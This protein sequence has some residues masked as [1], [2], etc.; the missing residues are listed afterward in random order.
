M[1]KLRI[2]FLHVAPITGDVE[3]NRRLVE[4]AV[5]VAAGQGADWAVTPELCIPGY[6]FMARIGT[7]WI[8]PQPDDWMRSFCQMVKQQRLTVFLSHPER[9]PETNKL[10][11]TVFVISPEGEIVGK[12]RKLR[13]LGGSEAWSSP[14]GSINPVECD[15]VQVGILICADAYKNEIA[16]VLKHKGAQVLVSPV[17]W[18]P[19][20]CGPDGE[21]EQRTADTGL[22]IMVCNRSGVEKEELDY[23]KA[24]SVVAQNGQRLLTAISDCSVVLT[25][26]WDMDSMTLLS[27]DY[28]RVYLQG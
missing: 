5:L 6:Q 10:Y 26:D 16:Q 24:E 14:G 8:L 2:S 11:N 20:R 27:E 22:P 15:G 1:K 4:S 9:D 13:T 17:A 19:G 18:G 25:F 3:H 23:R 28:H 12:H 21:W 7:D